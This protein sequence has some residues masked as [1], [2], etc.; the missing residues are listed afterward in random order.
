MCVS[1]T[2]SSLLSPV[3]FF[4]FFILK[5]A[6]LHTLLHTSIYAL[7]VSVGQHTYRQ[8]HIQNEPLS[9]HGKRLSGPQ[10]EIE[11]LRPTELLLFT[12]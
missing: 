8:S 7:S 4:S 9:H 6:R 1:V 11:K 3:L 5:S 2:K 10:V 12:A